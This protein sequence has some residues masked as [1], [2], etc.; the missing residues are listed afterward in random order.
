MTTA[1][2]EATRTT[3][4]PVVVG[5]MG[6]QSSVLTFA[7][8]EAAETHSPLTVMHSTG[9]AMQAGDLYADREVLG[10]LR[11]HGRTLLDEVKEFVQHEA[12]DLQAEYVLTAVP[13]MQAL[14]DASRGARALI[15]GSDH[16]PWFDR[17]LLSEVAGRLARHT[18]CPVVVVPELNSAHTHD[19]SI[20]LPLDGDTVADG[21]IRFAFEH[22]AAH[23]TAVRVLHVI[24]PRTLAD[25]AEAIK[26]DVEKV[27]AGWRTTYPDIPV[28]TSF[29]IGEPEPAIIRSTSGARLVV[30]ARPRSH[31]ALAASGSLATQV[32]RG[33]HCPVAV[34]PVDYAGA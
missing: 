26:A 28:E 19:G 2:H 3:T 8:Q 9:L 18:D 32:L 13:P 27:I 21:A 20:I 14:E 16:V 11:A 34:V 33:A 24:A 6:K 25:E 5:V 22:A 17:L 23:H 29:S 30:V 31:R 7:M 10:E 15:V 12:P 4:K 1:Q